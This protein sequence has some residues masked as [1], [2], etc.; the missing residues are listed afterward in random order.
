M[1]L[2]CIRA[3]ERRSDE[4]KHRL[5]VLRARRPEFTHVG[6]DLHQVFG[7]FR[8]VPSLQDAVLDWFTNYKRGCSIDEA[9][10]IVREVSSDAHRRLIRGLMDQLPPEEQHVVTHIYNWIKYAAEPLTLEMLAEAIRCSLPNEMAQLHYIKSYDEFSR[11][12]MKTLRGIIL[13]D[14]RDIRFSDDAFYEVSETDELNSKQDLACRPHADMATAC[15]R[16]LLGEEGQTMLRSLSV[17]SHGLD[18]H[19][20][21]WSPIMIPRNSL[22]S[23]ALRF[24]TVHYQA[25]GDYRPTDLASKLLEDRCKRRAWAEA[26][27]VTSNPFTRIQ[28]DYM[29]PLPYM[30]MFG[31]DDLIRKQIG[32]DDRLGQ[33]ALRQDRWLAIVEAA[34]NG[35]GKTVAL[36]LEHSETDVTGLGEALHWAANYG[37]GGALDVLLSKARGTQDFQWPP[38]I[39]NRATAA[40]LE[41][42]VSA[43]VHAGYDLNEED[44]DGKRRAVHTAVEHGEDRVLKILLDSGRVDLT[45]KNNH[46]ES[47]LVLAAQTGNPDSIRHLL[48]AGASINDC[49]GRLLRQAIYHGS[50]EALAVL[51]DALM[52]ADSDIVNKADDGDDIFVPVVQAATRGYEKCVRILL[53]RGADPNAVEQDGSALYHAIDRRHR[54]ICRML[55]EKGADPNGTTADDQA[56]NK[57]SMPL[58]RAIETGDKLLVEMLLD[59]GAKIDVADPNVSDYQTPLLWAIKCGHVD[60]VSLL[61]EQGA[62]ANFVPEESRNLWS[63]LFLAA[64]QV[65]PDAI[66][67]LIKHGANIHWTR[68][69][70]KWSV[71]HAAYDSPETLSMLIQAGVDINATDDIN[72]TALMWAAKYGR[73]K[74]IEVLLKQTNPRA[75]LEVMS[76]DMDEPTSTALHL[77]CQHF[78]TDAVFQL[79]EAG[80]DINRQRSDGRF[81][82]GLLLER[83]MLRE[84]DEHRL[85]LMLKRRPNLALADDEGASTVLH[86]IQRDTPLFVVMRLVE[87]GAPVNTFNVLGYN[88]LSWAV[89]V[90]N[91]AVA[92]YL[93][94]V[95][96]SQIDVHQSMDGSVLR[97]AVKNSSLEVVKALVR[98]GAEQSVLHHPVQSEMVLNAAIGRRDY[99]ERRKIIRYLVEE[100]GIDVNAVGGRLV[101]RVMRAWV[102]MADDNKPLMKYLLK[103]GTNTDS[104]DSV[105]R[106]PVHWAALRDTLRELKKLVKRGFDLSVG[107]NYGRTP[108]HFAA[109]KGRLEIVRY[110]LETLPK[111]TLASHVNAADVDGWTPLMWAC[112]AFDN[113][114]AELLVKEYK[115]DIR[116]RSKDGEWPLLKIARM[117]DWPYNWVVALQPDLDA[118]GHEKNRKSQ[119]Y[120]L[121]APGRVR[122][123]KCNGC[124]TV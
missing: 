36:L 109:G 41:S 19:D 96:G 76:T 11:F 107:D 61:L 70:D 69:S 110:I 71:L 42:L 49:K 83:S 6:L 17:D 88:P 28:K 106:T 3:Y 55:L 116:V 53:D 50:H 15:L 119:Y 46:G 60:I 78:Q 74:S 1:Q 102:G 117:H 118:Q 44:S 111:D 33:D 68:S 82:F 27:Y 45:L 32:N 81:P 64:L 24:W 5:K 4:A 10:D 39:L 93:I 101:S 57:R 67:T 90:G 120:S 79:L 47:P 100:A 40:G 7:K 80:A 34:R 124:D 115:A 26:V 37:E 114:V 9:A 22:I 59:H 94:N 56:D 104:P 62:D 31:L 103:H 89:R 97:S 87:E 73:T 84:S 16:Y 8:K 85:E 123:T 98:T 54:R 14:G 91:N 12:V 108:L 92:R 43:L 113:R 21:S 58:M 2:I 25:A 99:Q 77:A 52:L 48:D 122:S 13:L 72:W 23:Y 18:G 30:A 66:E 65:L 63:P 112:R 29:S 121:I 95:K 51:I 35:H 75:D 105:G 38:Y 86:N 20:L